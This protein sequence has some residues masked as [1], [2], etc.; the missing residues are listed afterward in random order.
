MSRISCRVQ[1]FL[2]PSLRSLSASIEAAEEGEREENGEEKPGEQ[3]EM[4]E[5]LSWDRKK[6]RE[7]NISVVVYGWKAEEEEIVGENSDEGGIFRRDG[8]MEREE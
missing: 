7:N 2:G 6:D 3:R 5:G 1:L 4:W 8:V